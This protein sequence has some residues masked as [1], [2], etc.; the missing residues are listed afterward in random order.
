MTPLRRQYAELAVILALTVAVPG[1]R[2]KTM[3][4]SSRKQH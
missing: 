2:R 1:L 3:G 4:G